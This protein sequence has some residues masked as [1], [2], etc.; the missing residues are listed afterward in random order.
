M[1]EKIYHQGC[2]G[3]VVFELIQGKHGLA[4][5]RRTK[6]CLYLFL[7]VNRKYLTGESADM[8]LYL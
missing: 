2:R 5:S 1:P 7:C 4:A 6:P 3:L 8:L